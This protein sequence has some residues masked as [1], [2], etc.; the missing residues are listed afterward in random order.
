MHNV[1]EYLHNILDCVEEEIFWKD[2]NS[3]YLGCNKYTAELLG[4]KDPK[5]IIGK[6]DYDLFPKAEADIL[7]YD[8]KLVIRTGRKIVFSS[9]ITT[10]TGKTIFHMCS[11]NPLY[12]KTGNIIGI[13]GNSCGINDHKK[14]E[15]I[16]IEK[17]QAEKEIAEKI[18]HTV[19]MI[20]GHIAHEIRTP[21]SIIGVNIDRLQAELKKILITSYQQNKIKNF[22]DNIQYAIRNSSNV[23]KTLLVVTTS[24][25]LIPVTG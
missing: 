22:T 15:W 1:N 3:V 19:E 14:A 12:D 9:E 13:I 4:L 11:K 10:A 25:K 24:C 6:T 23:I 8:D 2:T 18:S 20:A 5:D 7:T 16:K 21:L 17:V